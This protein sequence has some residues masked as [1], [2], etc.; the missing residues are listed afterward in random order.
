MIKIEKVFV[1]EKPDLVF[2]IGDVNSTLAASL[3]ASKL[4]IKIAHIESGL[5]S[6]DR[7][8]PEE[9]NRIIIDHLSDYLFVSEKSGVENLKK[10]GV[11]KIN[12]FFVGNCMIDTVAKYAKMLLNLCHG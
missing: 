2:V 6:N 12:I 10:E 4:K 9:I 8:M 11:S 5:R 7:D 1:L 3:V